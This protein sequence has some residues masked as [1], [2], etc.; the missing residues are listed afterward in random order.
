MPSTSR[1]SPP[2]PTSYSNPSHTGNDQPSEEE[3]T[4][5]TNSNNT[6][7]GDASTSAEQQSQA[8]G[9]PHS[10][11]LQLGKQ[12]QQQGG[13]S[14]DWRAVRSTILRK[15]S[16]ESGGGERE[17]LL[18]VSRLYEQPLPDWCMCPLTC[19]VMRDPVVAADGH[20]YERSAFARHLQGGSVASPTSKQRLS[21]T[22]VYPNT[23]L[24]QAI[25]NLRSA[26]L[27]SGQ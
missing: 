17:R 22:V 5:N 23:C 24:E 14:G 10:H 7:A 8:A 19:E 16:Q 9:K 25:K 4:P 2:L 26:T 18:D 6:A 21:S 20:S 3:T 15:A 11:N 27:V 12:Q 1:P 13:N